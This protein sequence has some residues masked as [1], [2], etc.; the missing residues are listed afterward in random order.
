MMHA[1]GEFAMV[2]AGLLPQWTIK[3]SLQ[4]GREVEG[5]LR[6]RNYRDFLANMYGTSRTSGATS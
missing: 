4:L 2:H 6:R 1:S 5:A 3:R